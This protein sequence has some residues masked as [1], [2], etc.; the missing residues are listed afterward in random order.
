LRYFRRND[1]KIDRKADNTP[2]TVA[3]REA[4]QLLRG[5]ISSQFPHDAVL[6]EEFGETSGSS[7]IQWVIDPIDGTKSFI[8]GVPLYTTLVGMLCQGVPRIGVIFAPATGEIVYASSGQGAW[9]ADDVNG[10][11]PRRARVSQVD[12]LNQS[13]L[14]TCDTA[15]FSTGR[16]PDALDVFIKLQQR[17]RI[18][19]T[20]GDGY[21]YLMVATGRAE[22]M[23]DPVINLWDIAAIAPIIT[24]AG[25]DFV[26][27][28]GCPT[29]HSPDAVG[30]NGKVT[31]ELLKILGNA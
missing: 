15:S 21:G 16:S 11:S 28:H 12:E 29:V 30:T 3:D 10:S 17:C 24:E 20:W 18:V 6:G 23:I 4:E 27:W 9:Y 1:V 2:V 25:G 13:L 7:D 31:A 8:H 14:L 5:E 22:V 19:R 26:D